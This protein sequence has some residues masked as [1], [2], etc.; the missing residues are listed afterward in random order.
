[1]RVVALADTHLAHG[2]GYAV[3]DG[4]LLIHAGDL[5]NWG[6][7]A[8]LERAVRWL[9]A[10]PHRHKV[11]IAGNHD[12]AC[13]LQPQE[14]RAIL[15]GV[16]YLEDEGVELDG[17]RLWGSP[18][19]PEFFAWAFNLPRGPALAKVWARIPVGL[20]ILVTHGPPHGTGDRTGW[21][22]DAHAGCEALRDR[23]PE[24]APRLHL[25]GHIHED[26]GLWRQ[27]RTVV[28]NVT[29]AECT[30]APTV[31]DLDGDE[32]VPVVVPPSG[33]RDA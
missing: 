8:E 20:D 16:I 5:C 9:E 22:R 4:D 17:L 3:P 32:L 27:G 13:Q 18:W 29:T 33:R 14:A 11:V 25:F 26:G 19:Q 24:V 15:G 31:I 21:N 10:L 2:P 30:R 28:A 1:M 23:L 12:R 7:L 6:D